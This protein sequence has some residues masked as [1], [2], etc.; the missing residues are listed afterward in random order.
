MAKNQRRKTKNLR[1]KTECFLSDIYADV[2][3][4]KIELPSFIQP[5]DIREEFRKQGLLAS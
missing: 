3:T 4:K 5:K 2:E 1:N